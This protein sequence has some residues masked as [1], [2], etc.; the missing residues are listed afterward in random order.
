M[1]ATPATDTNHCRT[2]ASPDL[3]S[4]FFDAADDACDGK[5]AQPGTRYTTFCNSCGSDQARKP[6]R[7]A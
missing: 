5:D 3:F 6:K 4:G 1:P 2:C 7:A